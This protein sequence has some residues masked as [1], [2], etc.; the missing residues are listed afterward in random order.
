M[1][2]ITSWHD[3]FGVDAMTDKSGDEVID[4]GDGKRSRRLWEFGFLEK[5][6]DELR[7]ELIIQGVGELNAGAERLDDNV[8][9]R[10]ETHREEI[11]F[12]KDGGNA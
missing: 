8:F 12:W 2:V 5:L 10:F 4:I 3:A 1:I 9:E 7:I 11:I 6:H